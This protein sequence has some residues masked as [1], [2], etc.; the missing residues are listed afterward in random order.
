MLRTLAIVV[1]IILLG[2]VGFAFYNYMRR[3]SGLSEVT[4]AGTE[5]SDDKAPAPIDGKTRTVI[6][7]AEITGNGSDYG[8][9][10][11]MYISDW[12]Y[13]FGKPK[14]ILKRVGTNAN[15]SNPDITLHPTDNSLQV[16]VSVFPTDNVAGAASPTSSSTGDSF[17]CTVE[18]VP[19]QS[20]FSV[21]VTVFQ[22]NM[23]IY[24]NGRLVKSCVLPG[25]PKPA[26]GDIILADKNGFS[27]SLCNVFTY[28]RMLTPSDA[29]DFF[30][31]GTKCNAPAP[32]VSK[33]APV[34][35]DSTFIRIF[36]Y[37]FRFSKLSR[38]GKE[39]SSYTF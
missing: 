17:T 5:A 15:V 27:G 6:P 36:G 22:R 37:T 20:W 9:Q 7:A 12:D 29:K 25:V 21:S 33:A 32:E 1:G 4:L 14:S 18:N 16:T 2:L 3:R 34:D 19:L 8:I 24:L 35:K 23:D 31:N 13:G 38:E 28:G 30:A 39:L 26:V 10:F 11:W